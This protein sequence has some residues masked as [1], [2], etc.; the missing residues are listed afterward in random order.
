VGWIVFHKSSVDSA[1]CPI[2]SLKYQ[3]CRNLHL[4]PNLRFGPQVKNGLSYKEKT[5]L[6]CPFL[7]NIHTLSASN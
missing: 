2:S 6:I 5:N 4:S 3:V 7:V 1:M